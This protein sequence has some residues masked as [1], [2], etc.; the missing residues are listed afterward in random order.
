MGSF[1]FRSLKLAECMQGARKPSTQLTVILLA[2][3][4]R[5]DHAR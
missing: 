5:A 1:I 4:I 2:L 3:V